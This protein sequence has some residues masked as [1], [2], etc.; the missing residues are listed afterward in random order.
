MHFAKVK[1]NI[2]EQVIVAEQEF[3]DALPKEDG[4]SW[5]Q[6]SFNTLQGKHYDPETKKEDDK[7]PLRGN[8]AGIGYVY[9][10][11]LDVFAP[12]QPYPSWT[13]DANGVWQPPHKN[14]L[15]G[16]VAPEQATDASFHEGVDNKWSLWDEDVYNLDNTKGWGKHE[17]D[18][19]GH[20]PE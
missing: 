20:H 12:P 5:L 2:V 18:H 19:E 9:D 8:Y 16:V 6:T 1:N 7:T 14:G 15:I 4:V 17:H 13:L 11:T 3:I 10:P